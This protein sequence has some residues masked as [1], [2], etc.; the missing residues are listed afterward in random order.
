MP[1]LPS[2]MCRVCN[3]RGW[4]YRTPT[5]IDPCELCHGHGR[6]T[7]HLARVLEWRPILHRKR[8]TYPKQLS[9]IGGG[10]D[11]ENRS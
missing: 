6:I 11:E 5:T 8:G 10:N 2:Q 1:N 3:G 7:I 4:F 9:L